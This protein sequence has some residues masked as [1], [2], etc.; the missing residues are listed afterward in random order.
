MSFFSTI[1][2]MPWLVDTGPVSENPLAS[3]S[4]K[5]VALVVFLGVVSSLFFL[6]VAAYLIR[7][8]YGDWYPLKDSQILWLNTLI[9]VAS[10]IAFQLARNAI[11][12]DQRQRTL[13]YL[14]LA[15]FLT[16]AFL[17][18]QL[19]VWQQISNDGSGVLVN[20]ASSFFYLLTGAH[21]L[22]LIGGLYVWLRTVIR[23][24]F[25][26]SAV[27]VK[28]SVELCSVYWHYLLLVWLVLL[29]LLF[30]T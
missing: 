24:L 9:L 20:P 1:T 30:S 3:S 7:M 8:S 21:G 18:A 4:P 13:Q 10:S 11:T 19:W 23:T 29:G 14:L 26:Y 17:S 25:G 6:F 12:R 15:G 27:S 2:E 28:L 16:L 22:H 5:K